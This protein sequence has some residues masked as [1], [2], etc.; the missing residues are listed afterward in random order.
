ML[1]KN[2]AGF[3][4]GIFGV[5]DITLTLRIAVEDREASLCVLHHNFPLNLGLRCLDLNGGLFNVASDWQSCQFQH[6]QENTVLL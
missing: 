4:F 2:S 1:Y 6:F 5:P 3:S